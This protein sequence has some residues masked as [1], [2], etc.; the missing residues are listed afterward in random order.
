MLKR[1]SLRQR[2]KTGKILKISRDLKILHADSFETFKI[3]ETLSKIFKKFRF[4]RFFIP[5]LENI[6]V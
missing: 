3:L 6:L 5:C 4:S 1:I 2:E